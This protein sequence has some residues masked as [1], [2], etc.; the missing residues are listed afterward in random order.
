MTNLR[1]KVIRLAHANPELRPHLLP[2]LKEAGVLQDYARHA[3]NALRDHERERYVDDDY[4]NAIQ[5]FIDME[6]DALPN[7]KK[8]KGGQKALEDIRNEKSKSDS[9]FARR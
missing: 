4:R 9:V 3:R 1:S 8:T 2:L 6:R 7:A 5:E